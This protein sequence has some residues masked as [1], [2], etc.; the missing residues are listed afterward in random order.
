MHMGTGTWW[1]I[2]PLH[3]A[4]KDGGER[5]SS[6]LIAYLRSNLE[7]VVET[8]GELTEGGGNF[9]CMK[10]E[11][12]TLHPVCSHVWQVGRRVSMTRLP[13]KLAETA[14]LG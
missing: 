2:C 12:P 14:L 11:S 6:R 4:Q 1:M 13:G 5:K 9:E 3:N 8:I 7:E 10:S